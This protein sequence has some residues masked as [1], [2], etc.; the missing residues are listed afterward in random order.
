MSL[1]IAAKCEC[2]GK[3]HV[4]LCCDW[5]ESSEYGSS[6]TCDK[7]GFVRDGWPVLIADKVARADE[8]IAMYEV[9]FEAATIT[10]SNAH[11]EVKRMAREVFG[12]LRDENAQI[13][14]G[15]TVPELV[16]SKSFSDEQIK[17]IGSVYTGA[18]LLVATIIEDQAFVFELDQQG[19]AISHPEYGMIG[20]AEHASSF[21]H[22]RNVTSR[23]DLAT[24]LYEVYEAKRFAEMGSEVGRDTSMYVLNPD[25][26]VHG[27]KMSYLN[28]MDNHRRK[29]DRDR[30]KLRL[31][32]SSEW[33]LDKPEKPL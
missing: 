1:C 9:K 32:A 23:D 15:A 29:A 14:Y 2:E 31:P 28:K 3:P 16:A 26:E 6:E 25:G 24:V 27:V 19:R 13:F 33:R 11:S 10:K 30:Q 5:L 8:L 17:R 21:L 12:V 18:D 4:V 20:S 7:F 22:W